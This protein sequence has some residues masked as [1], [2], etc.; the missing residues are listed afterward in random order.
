MPVPEPLPVFEALMEPAPEAASE[1]VSEVEPVARAD[2]EMGVAEASTSAAL[3]DAQDRPEFQSTRIFEQP[4]EEPA[5]PEFEATRTFDDFPTA[6]VADEQPAALGLDDF[7]FSNL[8]A[9]V[10]AAALAVDQQPA[11]LAIDLDCCARARS[12]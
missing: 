6:A 3:Q 7:D 11:A 12:P 8:A 5:H 2:D 1:P 9:Q 10:P 4:D